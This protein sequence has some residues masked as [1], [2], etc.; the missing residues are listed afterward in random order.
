MPGPPRTPTAI[1][2]LRGSWLARYRPDREL[3]QSIPVRPDWLDGE[4]AAHWDRIL[5]DLATFGVLQSVDAFALSRYCVMLAEWHRLR[6]TLDAEGWVYDRFIES[7]GQVKP[8]K[9]PEAAMLLRTDRM[10]C[11]I[12][13]AFGLTPRSRR[14]LHLQPKAK[15][16]SG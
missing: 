7:T 8:T 14:A 3:G 13:R 12:E 9:R 6:A 11:D 10:L 16:S 2:K 1:L 15:A 4:A 5:P